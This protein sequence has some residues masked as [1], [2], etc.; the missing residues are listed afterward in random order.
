M[1]FEIKQ[2]KRREKEESYEL[3]EEESKKEPELFS[4]QGTMEEHIQEINDDLYSEDSPIQIKNKDTLLIEANGKKHKVTKNDIVEYHRRYR[5]DGVDG[6]DIQGFRQ[7]GTIK[8]DWESIDQIYRD[9]NY[10]FNRID[11]HSGGYKTLPD[12]NDY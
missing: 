5:L 11:R 6:N 8:G 2:P 4:M 1:T 10:V 3:E 7:L 9:S 12:P